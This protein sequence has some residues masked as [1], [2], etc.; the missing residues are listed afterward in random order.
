MKCLMQKPAKFQTVG[1]FLKWVN[2]QPISE[3]EMKALQEFARRMN[4][5]HEDEIRRRTPTL[6][7]LNRV[8]S[9]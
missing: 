4:E 8:Y 3:E 2:Q 7:D 5:E 6:E 1:E 9:I